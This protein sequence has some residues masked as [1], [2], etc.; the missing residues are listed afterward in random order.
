MSRNA[1]ILRSSSYYK[2]PLKRHICVDEDNWRDIYSRIENKKKKFWYI[3]ERTL[4]HP[5]LYWELYGKEEVNSKTKNTSAIKFMD[6][7]NTRIYCKEVACVDGSLC[8]VC[9]EILM[10]K[11]VQK[12]NAEIVSILE[13]ISKY[14]YEIIR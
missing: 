7:E 3:V 8:I 11:K 12:N 9:V 1:V 2:S 6:V 5:K 4:T 13:K 14:E 10:S